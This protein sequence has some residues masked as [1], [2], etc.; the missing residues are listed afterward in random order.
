MATEQNVKVILSGDDKTGPAF[1]SA[2]KNAKG[3]NT[4]LSTLSKTVIGA[5]A[6][7]GGLAVAFGVSAVK[8]AQESENAIAQ[9]EAVLK[10]TKG[11][12]GLTSREV[13]D[14]ATSLQKMTTF[15]DEAILSASN[16][17]LTF[18]NIKG[19]IFKEATATVLDMSQALGQDLKSS[20]TQLGK[21]LNDPILGVSALRKVGVAFTEDQQKVIESLVKSGKTME[22][23][24]MI[25]QEL[26]VEFGGSAAAAAGT[27]AGKIAQLTNMFDDFKERVGGT[28]I[29]AI[30]PLADAL[31][32]IDTTFLNLKTRIMDM[33][34]A[35][36]EQTGVITF[37]KDTWASLVFYLEE[38]LFPIFRE[39]WSKHG[40]LVIELGKSMAIVFGG[41][42]LGAFV[43]LTTTLAGLAIALSKVLEIGTALL[44]V[45]FSAW[46]VAIDAFSAAW[47]KA[48][49]AIEAVARAI[50]RVKDLARSAG[51]KVSGALGLDGA[52]ANGGPVNA[53]GSYLVGERGPELF[54]PSSAG[55][56]V[57]SGS[58]GMASAGG[59]IINISGN[60]LLDRDAGEKIG[61]QIMKVLNTNLRI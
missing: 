37:L 58:F 52:R 1:A 38:N 6:A 22:A 15:G 60:T 61:A 11:A 46:K 55:N 29:E 44:D 51:S 35:L 24:K 17:L 10:S 36:N 25:L 16:L 13:Q 40:P 9:L 21:A 26:S 20:A 39:F 32:N 54:V 28:I 8:S 45:G 4:G 47:D 19:P 27:F 31:L 33:L 12:A 50:Q 43:I 49:K 56:I 34:D 5:T 7:V 2:G 53:G 48:G 30:L 23:Q 18:T 42:L 3:L 57:P 14:L 59:I 41:I